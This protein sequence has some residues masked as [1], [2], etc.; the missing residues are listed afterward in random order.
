MIICRVSW[1]V[2]FWNALIGAA[3]ADAGL[4]VYSVDLD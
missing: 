2:S 4:P 1:S 3:S